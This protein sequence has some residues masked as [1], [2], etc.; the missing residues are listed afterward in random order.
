MK[1]TIPNNPAAASHLEQ[2]PNIGKAMAADLHL[3]GID[4]PDQLS[5]KD[6]FAL[7]DRLCAISGKRH[8]P[9]II[10]VFLSAIHFMGS[11]EALP[12]WKFTPARKRR[13]AD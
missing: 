12:W 4:H 5:G 9:C 10:D 2:L 6:A 11:G 8:D 7:Y 3:I 1:K 13:Q